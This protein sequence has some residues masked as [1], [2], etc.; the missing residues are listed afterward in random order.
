MKL[1]PFASTL[2]ILLLA[3]CSQAPSNDDAT[4]HGSAA[5]ADN[6]A[7]SATEHAQMADREKPAA[8][9]RAKN[10]SAAGTV[11]S[12]DIAAGKITIAHGPV[13]A[14]HWPAMTMGFTASPELIAPVEVGQKVQ[15]DFEA[16]GMT[17][18]ITRIA[19]AQ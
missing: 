7:M 13:E 14:L 16:R 5:T 6:M 3:A 18:R 15:F 2:A 19:P 8:P 1:M 4:T 17:A 10:A 11:E 12:V 9:E